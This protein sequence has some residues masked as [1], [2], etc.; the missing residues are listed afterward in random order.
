MCQ[1][2]R[3]HLAGVA[4]DFVQHVPAQALG[5]VGVL[6]LQIGLARQQQAERV[7]IGRADH[8][9]APVDHRHF[10]VHIARL[11]FVDFNPAIEKIPVQHAGGVVQDGVVH[12]A[13]QQQLDLH[14]AP[15][16]VA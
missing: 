4:L 9:P 16:G 6:D 8:G 2:L 5:K 1:L 14:P 10:G 12:P 3:G 15:G 11:V 7:D 13:L